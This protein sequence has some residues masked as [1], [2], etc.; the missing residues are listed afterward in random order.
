MTTQALL[1]IV[2]KRGAEVVLVDDNRP[3]LRCLPGQWSADWR[4]NITDA[5][6]KV[7]KR[8]RERIIEALRKP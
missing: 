3:V 5:L 8:H 1:D 2:R 4:K 7:L 6:L